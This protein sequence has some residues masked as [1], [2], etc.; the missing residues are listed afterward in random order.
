MPPLSAQGVRTPL[1]APAPPEPLLQPGVPT[2]R[3][4][5]AVLARQPS[6][7][8]YRPGPAPASGT[9]PPL[10]P[11]ASAARC[12]SL[13]AS[14]N[15][16]GV[17]GPARSGMFRRFFRPALPPTRLLRALCPATPFAGAAFLLCVLPS[18]F[19]SRPRPRS[20]W[21][22]S[23]ACGRAASCPPPPTS[24]AALLRLVAAYCNTPM[25]L[26]IFSLTPRPQKGAG[27]LGTPDP[28][29]S[30]S[31]WGSA[32]RTS[33]EGWRCRQPAAAAY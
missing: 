11:T 16:R 20:A 9:K 2:G 4:P 5:L 32:R 17:R 3:P 28:P 23:A 13:A 7:P 19:A 27:G 14:R 8:R 12:R 6:L 1:P 33:R 21:A 24:T 29:F 31:E 26:V 10:S 22:L 25:L 15:R 30:F 18:G